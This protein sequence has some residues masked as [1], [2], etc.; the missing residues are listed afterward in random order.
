MKKI[1]LEVIILTMV[2]FMVSCSNGD[3]SVSGEASNNEVVETTEQVLVD[4]DV[5]KVTY[6]KLFEESTIPETCYLQLKVEN[7]SDKT[8]TIYPKDA[9]ANGTAIIIGSGV[10]MELA[11]GKNSQTPFFFTYKNLGITGVDEIQNVEFKLWAVDDDFET[12][13]ETDVLK[14]ER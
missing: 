13:I 14:I 2:V 12:V 11:T 5:I 1:L 8:L 9:Y 7:K 4:N 3:M 10:P 6:I